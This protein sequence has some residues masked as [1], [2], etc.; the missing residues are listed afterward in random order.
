MFKLFKKKRSTLNH[1]EVPLLLNI[2]SQL[3]GYQQIKDQISA[4]L[5]KGVLVG[6]SATPNYV[7]FSYVTAI[8]KQFE[9]N[10]M[11][12]IVVKGIKVLD[13]GLKNYTEVQIYIANGLITGYS[14]PQANNFLP[15][16]DC[17]V[18][19]NAKTIAMDTTDFDKIKSL[20]NDAELKLINASNVYEIDLLGKVYYHLKDIEDGNFIGMDMEKRI[21]KVTC[22]P[23]EIIEL[24]GRLPEILISPLV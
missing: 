2:F 24:T 18:V 19:T 16:I 23:F 7:G 10:F 12:D 14:T 3:A 9:N 13:L 1:W 11:E 17:I 21:Y 6:S 5:L 20:L 4:G 22:N 15:D 8:S